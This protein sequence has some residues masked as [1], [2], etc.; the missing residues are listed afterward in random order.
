VCTAQAD[1]HDRH[2]FAFGDLGCQ[3]NNH[4]DQVSQE[5]CTVYNIS[6]TTDY[7]V[8]VTK[9]EFLDLVRKIDYELF[10]IPN[11]AFIFLF[12]SML[13]CVCD[14]RT[15]TL[16]HIKNKLYNRLQIRCNRSFQPRI[17]Q[18]QQ[19]TW[20]RPSILQLLLKLRKSKCLN[21]NFSIWEKNPRQG[22]IPPIWKIFSNRTQHRLQSAVETFT[23]SISSRM[24]W[25]TTNMLNA[26]LLQKHFCHLIH[27]LTTTIRQNHTCKTKMTKH[28][29]KCFSHI[30]SFMSNQWQRSWKTSTVVNNCQN[31][32]TS[33]IATNR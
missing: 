12:F 26:K 11:F 27:E 7:Q 18:R 32:T 22:L 14:R 19:W 28:R 4:Q 8:K 21:R 30:N 10:V 13:L 17:L 3:S 29:H 24:I 33:S 15:Q 9:Q 16:S 31:K 20:N 2:V 6:L 25:T 23:R 5:L 1:I